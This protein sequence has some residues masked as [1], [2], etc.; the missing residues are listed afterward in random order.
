MATEPP[1]KLVGALVGGLRVLRYLSALPPPGGVGVTRVARDLQLNSSTCYNF[2][3]TLVYE[4]LVTFDET[5][6]T[7][8][9]G[10]GVVELAKGVLEQGSYVRLIHP[11]LEDIARIHRVTATLWQ[12]TTNERVVLV[13]RADNDNSVRVHMSVGQRL[14][15]YIAALGRC[16]AANS[17]LQPDQLRQRF[18]ALRW[19]DKPPFDEYLAGVQEARNQG[20][21]TDPGRYV[22]G[23]STASA[24][25]L[26]AF[27]KPVM[28]ISAVGFSAQFTGDTLKT[29]GEDLRDRATEITRALSGGRT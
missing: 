9:I 22:K 16:M 1:E 26:D 5:T 18:D 21:A 10:L 13:D 3:K 12:R 27:G 8:A 15:M 17:G 11:H 14:P 28:A 25:V 7:Y 6:K 19:D 4:G 23:V 2:L 29:L 24:A 20:Y